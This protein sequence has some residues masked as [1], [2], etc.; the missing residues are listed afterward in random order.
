M[1]DILASIR[2]ILSDEEKAAKGPRPEEGVLML[3]PS[4]MIQDGDPA[5]SEAHPDHPSTPRVAHARA[6]KCINRTCMKRSGA[7]TAL[8]TSRSTFLSKRRCPNR[9]RSRRS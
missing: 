3:D 8:R 9:S 6:A 7:P 1:D 5:A 2:R 4:M